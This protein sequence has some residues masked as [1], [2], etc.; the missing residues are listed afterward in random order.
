MKEATGE[1]NMTIVV[2]IAVGA[3]LAFL[4]MFMPDIFKQIKDDWK[5]KE[6]IDPGYSYV[7]KIDLS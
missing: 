1:L 5:N 6:E 3:V 7:E 4:T 2:I